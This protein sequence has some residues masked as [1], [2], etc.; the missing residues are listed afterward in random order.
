MLIAKLQA[1]YYLFMGLWPLLHLKSFMA[2]TGRK[3]DAWLVRCIAGLFVVIGL[4]LWFAVHPKE[5][6]ILGMGV[7]AVIGFADVYYSVFRWRISVVYLFDIAP[8]LVFAVGW[9]VYLLMP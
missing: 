5:V 2:V 4:Q 9:L 8:Q 1:V 6:W 3:A 7:A